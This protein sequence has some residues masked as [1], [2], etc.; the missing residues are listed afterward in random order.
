[1]SIDFS[2]TGKENTMRRFL[3]LSFLSTLATLLLPPNQALAQ[4]RPALEIR[5]GI[6]RPVGD[7]SGPPGV[8]GESLFGLGADLIVPVRPQLSIYVGA[9]REVFGCETC[10]GDDEFLSTG[11]EGGGK[12]LLNLPA[13][14]VLPWLKVGATFQRATIRAD[15]VEADSDWGLGFQG[16]VGADI[17]LGNVLSFAPALRYQTYTARFGPTGL[18]FLEAENDVSFISLDLGLHI[19]LRR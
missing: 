16:A 13:S 4:S 15:G 2:G 11:L 12:L 14:P 1:L 17:P 7:F 3:A 10:V 5:G 18:G 19:H 6:N 9:S 8:N